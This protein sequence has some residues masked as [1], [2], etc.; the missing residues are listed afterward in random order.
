VFVADMSVCDLHPPPFHPVADMSV[1][2][3]H[4]PRLGAAAWLVTAGGILS[5]IN[6][7]KFLLSMPV[8]PVICPCSGLYC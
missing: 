4:P 2:D 3:L 8:V 5:D 7:A 1:C 6:S